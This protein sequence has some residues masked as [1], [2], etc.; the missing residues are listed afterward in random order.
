[1][2]IGYSSERLHHAIHPLFL[3][4]EPKAA[5]GVGD[6]IEQYDWYFKEEE[7]SYSVR[8]KG[9]S[10]TL[11]KDIYAVKRYCYDY[12]ADCFGVTLPWGIISGIRPT[13]LARMIWQSNP[14]MNFAEF[15]S[16]LWDR[17][18][19]SEKK[20]EMLWE[21][22]WCE[23]K[24][25]NKKKVGRVPIKESGEQEKIH[26]YLGIPYCPSRCYYCSFASAIIKGNEQ[27]KLDTY[28]GM[29]ETEL[30][31]LS[32]ILGSGRVRTIYIGGG[33]PTVLS[34]E[35]LEKLLQRIHD[36]IPQDNIE[37]FTVEAGRPDTITLDK[38]EILKK[39][40]VNRISINPQTFS[41]QTLAKIG[42]H[43]T[44]EEVIQTFV[45]AKEMG[46]VINMDFIFGLKGE[47]KDDIYHSFAE[48]KKLRPDNIT[49]H[50][51]T[52][53]RSADLSQ[54]DR[55]QVDSVGRNIGELL[56]FW[57]TKMQEESYA[58]Y[59]LYRQK[60]IYFENVGYSLS[61]KECIYNMET[62][63]EKE[64]I[65]AIGAGSISKKVQGKKITRFEMPKEIDA[66][67]KNILEKCKE[68]R[69][70]FWV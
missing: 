58:P 40:G 11:T 42:R 49:V 25:F 51:L 7:A 70:L 12:Y 32:D 30:E 35:Q 44:V 13:K 67:S 36:T 55:E 47:T 22:L 29:L 39:Y 20:A 26:F 69:E 21:V 53:K 18:R 43:H 16:K 65:L 68:K 17:A 62:M 24:Y 34:A 33:T 31:I 28:L 14:D 9:E 52:A 27:G 1:M 37:E 61:G 10:R 50:T 60:N 64:S 8:Y 4:L 15:Y 41:N 23:N 54:K 38:L 57:Y 56:D 3:N 46:F 63:L 45:M 59:Y 6:D 48:I 19:V 2:K 5:W 66:Y